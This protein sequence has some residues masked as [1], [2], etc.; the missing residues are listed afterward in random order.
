LTRRN[1][2]FV[3][4]AFAAY[5]GLAPI[6]PAFN[7]EFYY[8]CWSKTPQWSY[9]DHPPMVAYMIGASTAVFGDTLFALR[10][11]ACL[12]AAVALG[13][14]VALTRGARLT[15][16]LLATPLFSLGAV[17]ITPDAPLFAFWSLYALWLAKAHERLDA[18][19]RIP[20]W[21]WVLGG[22]LLGAAVLG[23]YTAGLAAPASGLAFV[24]AG[25]PRR[26]W[27]GYL[28]HGAVAFL[29]ASP[30]LIHNVQQHFAP[31][32][33]QWQHT[34]ATIQPSGRKFAEFLG[35]QMVLF[36]TMPLVLLPWALWNWRRLAAEPRLRACLCLYAFPLL[37]F[38][39][40][41]TRGPLEG[42]WAMASYLSFWPLGVAWHA[43]LRVGAWRRWSV[44]ASFIAPAIAM[45][46]AVVHL[47]R[48]LPFIAPAAD[49][50]VL[51]QERLAAG[52]RLKADLDRM[53]EKLPVYSNSYQS[54]ALLRFC[55][56]DARQTVEAS[57]PS[58][59]TQRPESIAAVRRAYIVWD[60]DPWA[61]Q[62]SFFQ[63]FQ[64][65]A[66]GERTLLQRY[67]IN[68]RGDKVEENRLWLYESPAAAPP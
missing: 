56:I 65:R 5:C 18:T 15:W 4:L 23:K 2:F 30:I 59:F 66:T 54:I 34:M 62:D 16:W 35:V 45:L 25:R 1:F 17:L 11:P 55:G 33:L 47:V 9:Y 8:W 24:L 28:L 44:P 27:K 32:L 36:G 46:L 41:A 3:A 6:L 63:Q 52:Y 51:Q 67:P 68:I 14:A 61:A 43:G 29:V 31:L 57:R 58:H 22:A 20:G 39:F 60:R 49:R 7:D 50:I 26:W 48:P 21:S 64:S 13:V 37:F 19:D 38:L 40:K 53:P 10:L 42:N 12:C